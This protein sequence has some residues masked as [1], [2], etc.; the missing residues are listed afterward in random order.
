MTATS[1]G[2]FFPNFFS[3][4]NTLSQF[5][6]SPVA[7]ETHF[8]VAP[9]PKS[10]TD[11]RASPHARFHFGFRLSAPIATVVMSLSLV[12]S[13]VRAEAFLINQAISQAVL[14]N[15]G[16]GEA[17]ANRRATESELRQTQGT[18]LPQVRLGSSLGPEKFTEKVR[19]PPRGNGVWENGRE[20]SI[21]VRQ[22]VFDGF[23]S[24]HEVWRQSAR[25]DA[26]AFRVLERTELIALDAAEAYV[27]VVRFLRLVALANQNVANH[28]E[29]FSN[30]K[31][32]YSGGR[33]GEG[34]SPASA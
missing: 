19:L 23:A 16:V 10:P 13:E 7:L 32:R 31:S 25:V 26:A 18:L 29:L 20:V 5:T 34:R 12:S 22:I 15:P 6:A 17:A 30:V 33:A 11:K 1:I 21:I 3:L 9:N 2:K 4:G 27:D 14:T 28:E 24:I 8:R